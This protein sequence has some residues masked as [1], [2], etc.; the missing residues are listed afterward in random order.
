MAL[1]PTMERIAMLHTF[2]NLKAIRRSYW[3]YS[4]IYQSENLLFLLALWD[5]SRNTGY[6]KKIEAI[7]KVFLSDTSENQINLGYNTIQRC[8][9]MFGSLSGGGS[10]INNAGELLLEECASTIHKLLEMNDSQTKSKIKENYNFYMS[11]GLKTERVKATWID[12]NIFRRE[13]L[14]TRTRAARA[15]VHGRNMDVLGELEEYYGYRPW[16][17][18]LKTLG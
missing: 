1:R 2:S 18:E 13:A 4:T 10:R 7:Y 17:K 6:G 8:N 5:Y 9:Q 14:F 15:E 11:P 3:H 16:L 12:R